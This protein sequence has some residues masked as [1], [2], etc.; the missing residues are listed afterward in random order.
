[1]IRGCMY[2]AQGSVVCNNNGGL[3]PAGYEVKEH[4]EDA[5][6]AQMPSYEGYEEAGSGSF[7]GSVLGDIMTQKETENFYQD[8]KHHIKTGFNMMGDSCYGPL[9]QKK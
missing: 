3:T 9:C 8:D 4:Y 7:L 1:M 2:T 6:H 5:M